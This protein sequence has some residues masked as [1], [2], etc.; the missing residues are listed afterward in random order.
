MNPGLQMMPTQLLDTLHTL[1][2]IA[3]SLAMFIVVWW[4]MSKDNEANKKILDAHEKALA[5]L[6]I[7]KT[8]NTVTQKLISAV[9]KIE[10]DLIS[11]H[12][13]FKMHRTEDSERRMADLVSSVNELAKENRADHQLIMN[14]LGRV[15]R[16]DKRGE[17]E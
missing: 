12:T 4:K 15:E 17:D 2:A 1:F 9:E 11:H 6:Q 10:D 7:N 13:D 16:L 14:K 5:L 8:E 3:T